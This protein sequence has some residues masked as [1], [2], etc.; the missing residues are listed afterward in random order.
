MKELILK[1]IPYLVILL[2]F[3]AI[4][5]SKQ[6]GKE[7]LLF[8]LYFYPIIYSADSVY[9]AFQFI[10]YFY[11][12]YSLR[13]NQPLFS[14]SK[15]GISLY[16]ILVL[17]LGALSSNF[18]SN[19]ILGI[20]KFLPIIIFIHVLISECLKDK[21]FVFRV[22]SALKFTL[23]ISVAFL[24]L[25]I[26]L[27]L[28]FSL[29]TMENPNITFESI[30]YPGIF[31]DPQKHAQFLSALA[32]IALIKKPGNKD[33]SKYSY[34]LFGAAVIGLF[35]TG[36]RAALLGLVLGIFFIV[37]FSETKVKFL[38]LLGILLI[39]AIVVSLSQYLIVFSRG[40]SLGDSYAVRNAIW[41]DAYKMYFSHFWLGI[42]IDNYSKYVEIYFPDQFWL[43]AG[44]KVFFD[45]PENGY[46]KFLTELGT[47]GTLGIFAFILNAITRGLH[48]FLVK[49]KDFNIIFLISALLSWFLG[50]YSVYSLGDTR[51]MIL[52]ATITG[53]LV[54]YAQRYN[55][56]VLIVK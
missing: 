51:I 10:T 41:Q 48:T 1:I 53:V 3:Y 38:G 49:V 46:L 34:Y 21:E 6:P 17:F 40:E 24:F 29:T 14:N 26:V 5:K 56:G 7:Y 50:F 44:E 15:F 9:S 4:L 52:I 33:Y 54:V 19:S 32:F 25:Q 39:G 36:G 12:L 31:Q 2:S 18:V 30:R 22:I 55:E 13:N 28:D 37:L 27:G 23:A 47:L 42:G 16:L 11:F 8:I 45:H 35:L 20:V 43:V